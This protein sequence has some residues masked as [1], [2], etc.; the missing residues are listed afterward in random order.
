LE[1]DIVI[2]RANGFILA[3]GVKPVEPTTQADRKD[4]V[5]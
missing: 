3:E 1:A 4:K 2:S 5:F